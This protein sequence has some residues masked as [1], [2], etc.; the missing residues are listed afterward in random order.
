MHRA[1]PALPQTV[2]AKGVDF[3]EPLKPAFPALAHVTTSPAASVI[4]TIVLLKV[5]WIWATPSASTIRFRRPRPAPFFPREPL[6]GTA[7]HLL[8]SR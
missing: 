2:A 8:S 4:V 6:L 5:A 1:P 3:L 7:G